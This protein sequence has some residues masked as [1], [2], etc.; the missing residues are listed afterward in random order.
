MTQPKISFSRDDAGK[1]L[2]T[3][4]VD[5]LQDTFEVTECEGHETFIVPPVAAS[6]PHFTIEADLDLNDLLNLTAGITTNELMGQDVAFM[7]MSRVDAV[8][9]KMHPDNA[10]YNNGKAAPVKMPKVEQR[11]AWGHSLAKGARMCKQQGHAGDAE[12]LEEISKFVSRFPSFEPPAA[13]GIVEKLML[14]YILANVKAIKSEN[15]PEVGTGDYVISFPFATNYG[16][17][18]H[19]EAFKQSVLSEIPTPVEN[20]ALMPVHAA[21]TASGTVYHNVVLMEAQAEDGECL[22]MWLDKLGVPREDTKTYS[23][24]GRIHR[25]LMMYELVRDERTSKDDALARLVRL[26]ANDTNLQ[27]SQFTCCEVIAGYATDQRL[28]PDI[29]VL[30]LYV[31]VYPHYTNELQVASAN[32]KAGV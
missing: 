26:A 7:W 22:S 12:T 13:V 29:D 32:V 9:N 19:S 8:L 17:L 4:T 30:Q 14:D 20:M 2:V 3:V 10:P 24:V 23:L 16:D 28:N 11:G 25:L 1:S 21:F 15:S 18:T 27:R 5:G 6:T 31:R